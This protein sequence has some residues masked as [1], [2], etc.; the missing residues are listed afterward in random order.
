MKYG[1]IGMLIVLLLWGSS[2]VSIKIAVGFIPPITMALI[3]FAVASALL[4]LWLKKKEPSSRLDKQD[5]LRMM[6]AGCLGV[7]LYFY[8][9]NSGVQL[10]TASNAALIASVIPILATLLD[11]LIYKTRLTGLQWSGMAVA[12]AGTYLAITANGQVQFAS[13]HF[14][15]NM[16]IVCAMVTWS[17]Y[18]LCNK[19]FRSQYSGLFMTTYQ[20]LFGTLLLL[21]LS[22]TEYRQWGPIPAAVLL[23]VLF[24]A[25]F[26]SACCY[27]LYIYALRQLDVTVTTMYLNLVPIVGV[28]GGHLFLQESVLPLQLVG[29]AVVITGIVMVNVKPRRIKLQKN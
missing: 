19:S 27:L 8:F 28:V 13:A 7:T 9:E 1:H 18:T 12:F 17:L 16:L 6:A 24:L 10:S 4:W 11:Q 20:N 14:K 21:P 2:F 25:V 15:G 26:C 22:L 29:G 3:R 23:H 5:V